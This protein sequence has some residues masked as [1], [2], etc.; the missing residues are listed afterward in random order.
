MYK[1]Q[2]KIVAYRVALLKWRN[3]FQGIA[4]KSIEKVK[5]QLEKLIKSD[6]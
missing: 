6:C 1:V 3:N 2:R 5:K 4:R